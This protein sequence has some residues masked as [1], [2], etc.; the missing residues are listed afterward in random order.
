MG[1]DARKKS[2]SQ[3]I[4]FTST[5][6]FGV[7][8]EVNAFDGENRPQGGKKEPEGI[9]HVAAV[10]A[11]V[12]PEDGV[13]IRGYEHTN[14]NNRWIVKPDASCGMEVVSPPLKGWRGLKKIVG[15]ADALR[16]DPLIQADHR[17]SVHVHLE[18]ADLTEKQLATVVAWWI[19]CEPVFLDAM[20][21]DRKL[22]RYCQS[23]GMN[24]IYQ[25]DG[26]YSD[27]DIIVRAGDIKYYTMT[28]T[29]W[30][31]GS[32]KTIEFRPIEG[33]G[34]RDPYLIK[35]WIRLLIHFVE[36]TAAMERPIPYVEPKNDD[37]RHNVTPWTSL[38]WMDPEHVL[39]LLGFNNVPVTIPGQKVAKEYTLSKG[40]LQTRNW[41]LARLMANMSRHSVGGMRY[42][43]NLELE[44]ILRRYKEQGVEIKPEEHISPK[45]LDQEQLY[46]DSYRI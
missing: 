15:V 40:M 27:K 20:P 36:T 29:N 2:M 3:H 31:N 37:E 21:L 4:S 13:E 33:A 17:C 22:N 35:N 41:F 44:R 18:V 19:K 25:H 24:N 14:N 6:R 5:R 38:V 42:H 32:R 9:Q 26:H 30:V 46:G 10:A 12:V 28:T 45:E 7:E 43:A 39:S 11:S 1:A 34:V 23:L 8:L 16:A